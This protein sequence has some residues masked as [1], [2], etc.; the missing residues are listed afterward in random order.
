MKIIAGNWK[1]NG[2]LMDARNLTAEL[3]DLVEAT[4]PKNV[5]V[6]L[7]PPY[8]HLQTVLHRTATTPLHIGAQD[9]SVSHNGAYTGQISAQML[10]DIGCTH[11]IIGHSER[12]L[13]LKE[14]GSQLL[15]KIHCTQEAGLTA[16]LCVGETAEEKESGRTLTVLHQQLTDIFSMPHEGQKELQFEGIIAYEP[17]WAIGTGK[18]ASEEDII[19]THAY[20]RKE[21]GRILG[22]DEKAMQIPLLY[23]GSVTPA[24][25]SAILSFKNVDGVLVGGASLKAT[26][27][28]KIITAAEYVA[29]QALTG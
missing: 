13:Y 23:G 14:T 20:I 28:Y 10:K 6:L 25:A 2:T 4:H 17:V 12:R 19:S 11:V 29:H 1:M 7:F 9:C 8:I 16:I 22:D 21:L 26:D 24:N 27:F 3:V 18:V 5:N 15:E